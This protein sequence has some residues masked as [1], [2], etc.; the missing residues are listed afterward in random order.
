MAFSSFGAAVIRPR[1]EVIKILPVLL[2]DQIAQYR[3]PIK[4]YWNATYFARSLRSSRNRGGVH[5]RFRFNLQQKN[6]FTTLFHV[7]RV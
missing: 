7:V 2:I 6:N 1:A 5:L 4:R 3:A